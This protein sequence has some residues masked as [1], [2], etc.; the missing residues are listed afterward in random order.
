MELEKS[1]MEV[2]PSFMPVKETFITVSATTYNE[3]IACRT[4]LEVIKEYAETSELLSRTGEF[5]NNILGVKEGG[6]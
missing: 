5:V 1:T 2:N 6:A 4:K 3:L